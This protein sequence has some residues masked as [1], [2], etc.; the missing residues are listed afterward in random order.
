MTGR[1]HQI[2]GLTSGLAVYILAFSPTY[3]PATLGA[4]LVGAHIG[5]LLPD[6]DQPTSQ[7]WRALPFGRI[8]GE[9][10]DIFL[11][12]RNLTH[13]LLGFFLLGWGL[14]ALLVSFPAYW[15]INGLHVWIITMVAYASHLIADAV[16]VEGI[17]LLFPYQHMFGIP[18][19]PFAGVRII[20]G[21]WFEN[22]IIFPAV[23][24]ALI[25]LIWIQWDTLRLILFH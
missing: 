22:L 1:T 4:A 10:A 6:I 3:S 20:T 2:I 17:P 15:G 25:L 21:G 11:K 5:A 14:N 16:T 7:L 8:G 24:I 13:S 19:H 12:H 23:N 9:F 18:P